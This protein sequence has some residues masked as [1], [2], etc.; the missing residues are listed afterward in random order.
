MQREF[1]LWLPI[2]M[3]LAVVVTV[4][5]F[6]GGKTAQMPPGMMDRMIR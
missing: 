2:I 3:T 1:L 5:K 6:V 4:S